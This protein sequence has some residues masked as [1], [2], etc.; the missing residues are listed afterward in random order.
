M[1]NFYVRRITMGIVVGLISGLISTFLADLLI[2]GTIITLLGGNTQPI[3][4]LGI[5]LL[6][7]A[8]LGVGFS[9]V[10]SLKANVGDQIMNG[11][12]YAAGQWAVVI[13]V[14]IPVL[15]GQA[16][17]W[18]PPEVIL[19]FPALIVYLG[20]GVLLALG[21]YWIFKLADRWYGIIAT[22][23]DDIPEEGIK[24][25]VVVLGGGFGGVT[26]AQ[27][28]EGLLGDD[29]SVHI[30]LVSQT[31]HLLFTPM[32]AEVTAGGVEAQHISPPLRTFFRHVRVIRGEPAAINI[33]QNTVIIKSGTGVARILPY[34]HLVLAVGAVP[35][36]FGN[37]NIE[38][39]AFTFKSLSDAIH[40]RNHV[41]D[42]LER[43]DN[44]PNPIRRKALL[45]FVVVGAGFAGSELIGGLNDF[46]RGSLWYYKHLHN[47]EVSLILVH[48]GE[49]ILPELST[50][51]AQYAETKMI[52]RGVSIRGKARVTDAGQGTV[53][54]GDEIL[55]AETL[56]WTA[57][58]LPNPV[59]RDIGCE[60]DKRGAVITDDK[61]R[62]NG[63]LNVW[64]IGDCAS[65]PDVVTGKNAPPTAQYALREAKTLAYNLH[66]VIHNRPPKQFRHHSQGALAVVGHQ[67]ACAEVFGMQFSGLF[68]WLLWR[69]IY[70]SKLPT[71]EKKVRV[72][73]DWVIDV[74]FPRDI[75]YAPVVESDMTVE[76]VL[77]V[78]E[79]S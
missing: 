68:A 5:H 4:S 69:G 78:G 26:T 16:P 48:P 70:L 30:T 9:L 28:L 57:G 6:F 53:T 79:A 22:E 10:S 12:V 51:L 1:N 32:L 59:I 2:G 38:A 36:F 60:T 77:I 54:I 45:T 58:N 21:C 27:Q 50:K 66:A 63:Q 40:I 34:D 3:V 75:A 71:L 44:E 55:S 15:N 62:V 7:S 61:L 72:L 8:L 41:I 64:G 35:N 17:Q 76:E 24:Q 31:N 25:R 19:R 43:A 42:L 65:I 18:Q 29:L 13:L 23:I 20:Q 46:V 37:K 39:N 33:A 47:D 52:A 11:L 73:L 74:F 49:Q 14:V 67:T 56:I